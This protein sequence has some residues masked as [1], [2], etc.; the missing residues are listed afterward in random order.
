MATIEQP[1]RL[2]PSSA[3]VFEWDWTEWCATEGVSLASGDI[4]I[5]TGPSITKIG[6]ALVSGPVVQVTLRLGAVT[7]GYRTFADCIFT[8]G[9]REIPR[10]IEFIAVA[11]GDK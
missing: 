2:P 6:S 1:Y 5:A 3:E 7:L 4:S 8:M 11:R 9:S 10:R